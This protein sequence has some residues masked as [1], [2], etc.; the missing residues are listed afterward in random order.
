MLPVCIY[1]HHMCVWC[2]Q[3]LEGVGSLELELQVVV[4]HHVG[5]GTECS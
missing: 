2:P 5:A 3:M 4:D 1:V